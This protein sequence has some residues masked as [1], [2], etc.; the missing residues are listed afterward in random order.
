MFPPD[1]FTLQT[2]GL[3]ALWG[4]AGGGLALLSHC[5]R[6]RDYLL[7]RLRRW[8]AGGVEPYPEPQGYLFDIVTPEERAA[9]PRTMS[10]FAAM[11]AL[12]SL[13]DSVGEPVASFAMPL[14]VS[15]FAIG[16]AITSDDAEDVGA[17][18]VER[19]SR[20]QRIKPHL[21]SIALFA[22]ILLAADNP[23]L[24]APLGGIIDGI[25]MA[26]PLT[27]GFLVLLGLAAWRWYQGVPDGLDAEGQALYVDWTTA[28]LA[29][30]CS[31][32]IIAL[33]AWV[34]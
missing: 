10:S 22:M 23:E 21:V 19:P 17:L 31:L 25:P 6:D 3:A 1:F 29:F 8:R 5:F 16:A 4:G 33:L 30:A 27:F 18:A 2:L 13:L 11:G 15:V 9:L 26:Y 20:W 7:W 34:M 12:F 28:F 24:V 32:G 14:A